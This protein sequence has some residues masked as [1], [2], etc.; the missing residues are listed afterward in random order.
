MSPDIATLSPHGAL[1][2]DADARTE[3]THVKPGALPTPEPHAPP[4]PSLSIRRTGGPWGEQ[5][6]PE[7]R[8]LSSVRVL[9]GKQVDTRQREHGP[10]NCFCGSQSEAGVPVHAPQE[11]RVPAP[12][13]R[14]R[15][16]ALQPPGRVLPF[17]SAMAPCAHGRTPLTHPAV[18]QTCRTLT[19][20]V[21]SPS[22]QTQRLSLPRPPPFL[23]DTAFG[24][25][26][27]S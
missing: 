12:G 7:G 1:L 4:A 26:T 19:K 11:P 25:A 10:G 8:H 20:L 22:T 16:G 27:K 21:L 23:R 5:A 6:V 24:R 9:S 18:F 2:W 13:H 15:P 17:M 3:E 14:H